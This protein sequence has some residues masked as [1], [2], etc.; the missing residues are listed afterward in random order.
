MSK[1]VSIA[2]VTVSGVLL[3]TMIVLAS[4]WRQPT[5]L[6]VGAFPLALL[7]Y[8]IISVKKSWKKLS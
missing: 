3:I 6:I 7:V 2:F 5:S 4:L 1:S 8:F